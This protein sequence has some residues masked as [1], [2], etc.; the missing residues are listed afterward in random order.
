MTSHIIPKNLTFTIQVF[1]E[2]NLFVSYNPELN[3]SSCGETIEKAKANLRD[4]LK[5]FL[6]SA[7]K[8]GTL[9][10]ILEEAGYTYR[11]KHWNDPELVV[12]DRVTIGS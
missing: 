8:L 7:A 4:A 1:R 6:K 3:V 9:T 2:R 10:A 12:M 11:H 5:G